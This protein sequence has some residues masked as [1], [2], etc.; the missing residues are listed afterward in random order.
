MIRKPVCLITA[1][2]I[3]LDVT[4]L[5]N[6]TAPSGRDR[7]FQVDL[8]EFPGYRLIWLNKL[9]PTRFDCG[10][11]IVEPAFA[12]EYS[13]SVY[14]RPSASR[15]R[16]YFVTYMTADQNLWQT[17]DAGRHPKAAEA[18]K[19]RRVDCE[20]PASTAYLLRQAWIQMLSGSQRPRPMR[21]EDAARSTDATI[22]EFSIR[23]AH[24]ETLYGEFAVE[25]PPGQKT[26]RLVELGGTLVDYC[27]ANSADRQTIA[28]KLDRNATRLFEMLK[29]EH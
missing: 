26:R 23:L 15:P 5:S 24:G 28:A 3:S 22:A 11:M 14:S 20:I 2:A 25:L 8:T 18:A 4:A 6:A 27:K 7:L 12:P 1:L 19:I 9:G 17:T 13:V 10:R 29:P 16:R 21:E